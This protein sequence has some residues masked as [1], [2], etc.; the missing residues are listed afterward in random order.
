MLNIFHI[1]DLHFTSAQTG[2]VR[3]AATAAVQGLLKLA[4]ELKV[5]GILSPKPCLFITGDLVQSGS[6]SSETSESDFCA[7][8][9]ELLAPL[10]KILDIGP[11]RVFIVPGN[12]EMDRG[13]VL[14]DDKILVA[15]IKEKTPCEADL[16]KDL[17]CKLA[18]YFKFITEHGYNSVTEENPRLHK[19]ELE[20]QTIICFNGLAGSYS[21]KGTGDKGE[22]LILPTEF[23]GILASIPKHAI[24][25]T[26]HP[27]SWFDDQ[28]GESLKELLSS[29]NCRVMTGHIHNQGLDWVETKNGSLALIQAGASA[30]AGKKN[31]V[32]VAW[33]T[34]SD[35]AA[36]RHYS[37]DPS[38]GSFAFTPVSSTRVVPDKASDYF[39]KTQAFFDPAVIES[40]RE[41]AK[42][43]CRSELSVSYRR[44]SEKYVVPDL[45][46]YHSDHFSGK[47]I[48]YEKFQSD[49]NCRVISGDEL[50]GKTSFTNYSAML[51][52]ADSD[53]GKISVVIDF[54]VLSTEKDLASVL[55]KKLKAFGLSTP[56]AEHIFQI[57]LLDLWFDN[58]DA[59]NGKAVKKFFDFTSK[60]PRLRWTLAVRGSQRYLHSSS[61]SCFPNDGITYYELAE[62]SLPTVLAMIEC[63]DDG[64]QLDK[65]RAVVERVF[66]SINNL[67]A[68]RTIF[69][70]DSLVD[71]FLNNA[72][73]EPLNRYLL[74]ENLLSERIR[75]AHKLHLP[76]QAVDMEM[77]ETFIGKVAH[78]LL[79]SEV[80]YLS[81]VSF[82]NL[83]EE[84]VERKGIQPKRFNAD[85]I[86]RILIDSFVLREYDDGYAFMMLSIEDYFLA[87]HMGRDK[88]F[89]DAVMSPAGLLK[90]PSVAEYYIAQNPSDRDRINQI[91]G[92]I[93]EFEKEVWPLIEGLAEKTRQSIN[94]AMP[95]NPSDLQE[96]LIDEFGEIESASDSTLV[97]S[98]DP[99]MVGKT[100]RMKFSSEERGAVFLQLG[101]S[102]LGV[103]RTL[104]QPERVEI[105]KRLRRVLLISLNGVPLIAQHLADGGEVKVRGVN[106]KAD[107]VGQL[108]KDDDRFYIILRGMLYNVFRY[109]A[110][111]AGS[112]SFFNAAVKLRHDEED[113]L[114]VAALF[115]QNIEADLSEAVQFIPEIPK[116]LSSPILK[117]IVLRLFMDAMSLVPLDRDEEKSA[118]DRLVE[119]TTAINPPKNSATARN[120]QLHKNQLRQEFIDKIGLS[121]YIGKLV[122]NPKKN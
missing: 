10:L 84:F 116:A 76:D 115:A 23:G 7:V 113:E 31:D 21:H 8:Q 54:R 57:G 9:R 59:D 105:F 44:P 40:V 79:E 88:E 119:A 36:V 14:D 1:S 78:F 62:I 16:H 20:G 45:V 82:Y 34:G 12:H 108:S 50:S 5:K 17:R 85:S 104:D 26:H 6:A 97:L 51:A 81:K 65:P 77:V 61:P 18:S 66:R 107:Y 94:S 71:M 120:L 72:A 22:L 37:F 24:I 83:V 87:K 2:L 3:D 15:T 42:A 106:V 29:R 93:E 98:D 91:F 41:R 80:P 121:A 118:I 100:K 35:S 122:R 33:L 46:I 101:S 58:F 74:I 30:E 70:V 109:F 4:S 89:K 38:I 73:V 75:N 64:A 69:Y 117:E 103:T 110:T 52:N 28:C 55:I 49:E 68:P 53:G 13:A 39:L 11:E 92:I 27:F 63:H 102:I 56:Q 32:A 47:R 48:A 19:F 86:L 114:I 99:E 60:W 112:P 43:E 67:R 25:L 96:A 90:L 95:G 111:W